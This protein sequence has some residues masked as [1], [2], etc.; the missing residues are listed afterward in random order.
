MPQLHLISHQ[1]ENSV[2]LL[3]EPSEA[4]ALKKQKIVMTNEEQWVIKSGSPEVRTS[5]MRTKIRNDKP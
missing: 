3:S 2:T 5:S 1:P 4:A